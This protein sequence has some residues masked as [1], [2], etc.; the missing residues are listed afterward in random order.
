MSSSPAERVLS[1]ISASRIKRQMSPIIRARSVSSATR[2]R[3]QLV[4]ACPSTGC[5]GETGA[6][7]GG[8]EGELAGVAEELSVRTGRDV[9]PVM[10]PPCSLA[11]LR[12]ALPPV[13][14]DQQLYVRGS[15]SRISRFHEFRHGFTT[16]SPA[17]AAEK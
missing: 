3:V 1:G 8:A 2:K 4:S 5:S 9:R 10:P 6:Q 16:E 15:S 17:R 7:L 12:C 13:L 14:H 11:L